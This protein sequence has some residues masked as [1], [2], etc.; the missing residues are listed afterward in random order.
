MP[1]LDDWQGVRHRSKF[2]RFDTRAF[3]S[4]APRRFRSRGPSI[5]DQLH[6][7][8]F[9]IGKRNVYLFPSGADIAVVNPSAWVKG[10]DLSSRFR[11]LTSDWKEATRFSSSP[12]E[13]AV[14]PSYQRVIG[15]GP[16]ALPLIL[17][18]LQR[19]P[20]HWFWALNAIVG[21]DAADQADTLKSAADAWIAWGRRHELLTDDVEPT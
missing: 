16:A 8:A 12:E 2:V 17:K 4:A 18:D 19:E 13:I 14:H 9:V 11:V 10:G 21:Y 20:H 5:T 15:M 1:T 7:T 6:R 3:S